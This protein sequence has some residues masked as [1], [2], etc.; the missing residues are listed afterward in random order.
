[1]HQ[2]F[3]ARITTNY[4]RQTDAF[5]MAKE[6]VFQSQFTAKL[7]HTIKCYH[8]EQQLGRTQKGYLVSMKAF[9]NCHPIHLYLIFEK[10]RKLFPK[11]KLGELDFYCLCC[12]VWNRQKNQVHPT[13]FLKKVSNSNFQNS[14]TDG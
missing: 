4:Y 1:M 12:L 10:S 14:S 7:H 11:I 2:F 3:F 13:S 9:R 6:H 5:L 8:F